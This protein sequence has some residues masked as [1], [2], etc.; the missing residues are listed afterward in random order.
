MK[1]VSL[2]SVKCTGLIETNQINK[3][4]I[5][6]EGQV[7]LN[8]LQSF[9]VKN[10]KVQQKQDEIELTLNIEFLQNSTANKNFAVLDKENGVFDLFK[11]KKVRNQEVNVETKSVDILYFHEGRYKKLSKIYV[12]DSEA[13]SNITATFKIKDLLGKKEYLNYELGQEVK[14]NFDFNLKRQIEVNSTCYNQSYGGFRATIEV[15]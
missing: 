15:K 11:Y 3:D 4:H 10:Y 2:T 7:V 14:A 9:R 8:Q 1:A 12:S 13:A 5:N 6:E